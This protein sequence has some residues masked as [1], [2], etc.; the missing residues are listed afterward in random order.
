[1]SERNGMK[2]EKGWRSRG[3]ESRELSQEFSYKR[4]QKKESMAEK[5]EKEKKLF[6]KLG[7]MAFL[8]YRNISLEKKLMM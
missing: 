7:S 5:K 1:M 6:S 8:G 2:R 3:G 4:E